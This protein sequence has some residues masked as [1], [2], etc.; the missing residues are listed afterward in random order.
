MLS[1][2]VD[3][4]A[5]TMTARGIDDDRQ[6]PWR[7]LSAEI[8][9]AL[10]VSDRTM[11][12]RMGDAAALVHDFPA[13]HAALRDG[14][15]DRVRARTIVDVGAS[16]PT[17]SVRAAFETQSLLRAEDLTAGRLAAA[18]RSIAD[19][20]DPDSID[21]RHARAK[22]RRRVGITDLD[23]GMARLFA[24]LPATLARA[25]F[26]RITQMAKT[27]QH[28]AGERVDAASDASTDV[29]AGAARTDSDGAAATDGDRAAGTDS[30]GSTDGT[31]GIDSESGA[32][33]GADTGSP[34]VDH[35]D[36]GAAPG[37][38]RSLDQI[39]ADV[40][41]DL[42]LTSVP[43]GHGPAD[44]FEKITAH[45]QVTVP[46]ELLDPSIDTTG[47]ATSGDGDILADPHIPDAFRRIPT[48]TRP[49]VAA[50]ATLAGSGPIDAATARALAGAVHSWDRMFTDPY[51]G[52]VLC[53]DRHDPNTHLKRLL[54]ARDEHC[55]FPGCR[56]PVWRC[57]IDHTDRYRD[58]GPTCRCNLEHLCKGHHILKHHTRWK[59]RQLADG[60]LEWTSPTGRVYT[61]IPAPMVRFTDTT[62]DA[63]DPPPF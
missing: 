31:G 3:V 12:T 58:G 11:Q 19:R 41:S 38:E 29:A 59:V 26:D 18:C 6:L 46:A 48:P 24:D 61:D 17:G 51:S 53:V 13:V 15:I 30:T 40:L 47:A 1:A 57:E 44:V 43:T 27:V 21:E 35:G 60:V 42:L 22:R 34:D 52:G 9:A 2:A 49:D 55:R 14:R 7:E 50:S 33:A 54:A 36:H 10:R 4:V 63:P 39:R 37:D 23:D 5:E 28:G 25:I 8:A 32:G 62:P 56:Q 16:L 20:L 45:V